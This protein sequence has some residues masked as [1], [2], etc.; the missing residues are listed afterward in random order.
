M[1]ANPLFQPLRPARNI[2]VFLESAL[3][4]D[5][6]V[7]AH[8]AH[9]TMAALPGFAA[10][11]DGTHDFLRWL[12]PQ[13][14]ISGLMASV[15]DRLVF[16][17]SGQQQHG[18][19]RYLPLVIG[20]DGSRSN[21]ALLAIVNYLVSRPTATGYVNLFVE[22]GLLERREFVYYQSGY[23]RVR[24]EYRVGRRFFVSWAIW[25]SGRALK[26]NP[27]RPLPRR[28]FGQSLGQRLPFSVYQVGDGLR[29]V[30]N[31]AAGVAAFVFPVQK[32][33]D[34]NGSDMQEEAPVTFQADVPAELRA[35]ADFSVD[36]GDPFVFPACRLAG[37]SPR[38]KEAFRAD[39][40]AVKA[41]VSGTAKRASHGVLRHL[42]RLL[43]EQ[44]RSATWKREQRWLQ[45]SGQELRFAAEYS[46]KFKQH[47]KEPSSTLI[48]LLDRLCSG[49]GEG[50]AA[51]SAPG[52]EAPSEGADDAPV[53]PE[54]RRE[55]MALHKAR[56]EEAKVRRAREAQE[57]R[58]T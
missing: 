20:E 45:L 17:L 13:R 52:V 26:S 38:S 36:R 40:E 22:A 30:P 27:V 33:A 8:A 19:N 58:R 5:L 18:H 14:R 32:T 24:R 51:S 50:P 43:S 9:Q 57:T 4:H 2:D 31:Q 39:L 42:D 44:P 25:Q 41:A 53:T 6:R 21:N 55:L 56:M 3:L 15:W 29:A 54:R 23:R 37:R 28:D 47:S 34:E 35:H 1:I 12:F 11:R 48:L 10:I 46:P 49:A 7:S 16:Y